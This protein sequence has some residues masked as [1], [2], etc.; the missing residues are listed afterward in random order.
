MQ[1]LA[2]QGMLEIRKI[3]HV[4]EVQLFNRK[5]PKKNRAKHMA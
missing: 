2:S 1:N 3:L 4:N 5:T